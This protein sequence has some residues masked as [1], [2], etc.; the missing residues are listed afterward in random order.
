[1]NWTK[2]FGLGAALWAALSCASLSSADGPA[3]PKKNGISEYVEA[4]LQGYWGSLSSELKA[5]IK[6]AV[7]SVAEIDQKKIER[8]ETGRRNILLDKGRA[9]AIH[10]LR[11]CRS[12]AAVQPLLPF[13]GVVFQIYEKG[14]VNPLLKRELTADDALKAIGL[15]AVDQILQSVS[16][17]KLDKAQHKDAR[18]LLVEILGADGVKERAAFLKLGKDEKVRKFLAGK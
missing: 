2:S 1:M 6:G 15:P 9:D 13:I 10:F 8:P 3:S 11:D 18:K 12:P 16:E 17:G 5:Q 7:Q 14:A 4:S